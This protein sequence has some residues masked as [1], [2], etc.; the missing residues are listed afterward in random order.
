M[1]V[2]LLAWSAQKA[3]EEAAQREAQ[4]VE[5]EAAQKAVWKRSMERRQQQTA[6]QVLR[7][8]RVVVRCDGALEG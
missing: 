4:A 8:L 1:H 7:R 3:V 5:E 6:A 2:K